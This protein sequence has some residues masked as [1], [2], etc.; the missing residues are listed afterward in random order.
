MRKWEYRSEGIDNVV[1]TRKLDD[2]LNEQGKEGWELVSIHTI[3][4]DAHAVFKRAVEE[5]TEP[6]CSSEEEARCWWEV[7]VQC[8]SEPLGSR[9]CRH[10]RQLGT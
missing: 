1:V 6:A 10:H 2:W 4:E 9:R 3:F 7:A 8:W 5:P